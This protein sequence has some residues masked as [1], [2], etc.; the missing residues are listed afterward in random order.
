MRLA[1]PLILVMWMLAS[2]GLGA[3]SEQVTIK[4]RV[5]LY[6]REL[7]LK[8]VPHLT[9]KLIPLNSSEAAP[10][11]VQ[12]TLDG[13]AE[14]ELPAGKYHLLTEKPVELFEK[15]YIWDYE[16]NLTKPVNTIELSNDNA[17]VT[18]VAGGR[19]ARVDE[20]AYQYKSAKGSVVAVWTDRGAINGFVVDKTGLILTEH[21]LFEEATSISVQA[22]SISV[23]LDEHRR[24]AATIAA[25]DKEKDLAVLR[26]NPAEAGDLAAAKLSIDPGSLVEGERV[27]AVIT[28]HKEKQMVTG[29]VSKADAKEIVSDI[30]QT[31]GSPLFNSSGSVVGIM[32]LS[33]DSQSYR[34]VPIASAS[35]ILENARKNVSTVA[36]P[37]SRLLP[38]IPVDFYPAESLRAPGRDRF[39]K[40]IYSFKTELFDVQLLTPV[41]RY[42][43]ATERYAEAVKEQSRRPKGQAPIKEPEHQY[44][45]VLIISTEPQ[46]TNGFWRGA[47]FKGG[48]QRM[49]LL[50]GDKEID[51]IWPARI[52]TRNVAGLGS[53]FHAWYFYGAD[54]IS[55]KCGTVKIEFYT[56]EEPEKPLVK[57]LDAGAVSRIWQDFDPYRAKMAS[58][59]PQ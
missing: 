46:V 58:D 56:M 50:C 54:A 4:L 27:F 55:P 14:A 59:R 1:K 34:I 48:L 9:I 25:V 8:P 15:L 6:D 10:A 53:T 19:D 40:E 21:K 13:L 44:E 5:A 12:T 29:V 42:E 36:L 24:L 22:T 20:L 28:A 52:P 47:H 43:K 16:I 38:T 49:R 35:T 2:V 7:N 39:E 3:A 57:V 30:R 45:P 18:P 26:I 41:A 23:Q 33:V 31:A 51:P 17:K 32:L 37:S 11:I